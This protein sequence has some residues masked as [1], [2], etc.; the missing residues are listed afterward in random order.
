M[1]GPIAFKAEDDGISVA[2][3]SDGKVRTSIWFP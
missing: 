1:L 3:Y 2:R